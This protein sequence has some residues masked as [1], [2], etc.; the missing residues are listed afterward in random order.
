MRLFFIPVLLAGSCIFSCSSTLEDDPAAGFLPPVEGGLHSEDAPEAIGYL[1]AEFDRRLSTWSSLKNEKRNEGD[2]LK[3]RLLHEEIQRKA[4]KEIGRLIQTLENDSARKNREVAAAALGFSDDEAALS[5]LL[6]ALD[7]PDNSVIQKALFGLGI[8][9]SPQTPLAQISFLMTSHPDPITRTNASFALLRLTQR[10]GRSEGLAVECR[11]ALYDTEAGVRVQA[12][13]ILGMLEDADSVGP[14][15]DLL[16]DK[17]NLV[18]KAAATGL[19]SI[20]MAAPDQKARVARLM[21]D[22]YE[23]SSSRR[24]PWIRENMARLA[25]GD[26]GP[27]LGNWIDWAYRLP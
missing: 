19:A 23:R 17:V 16:A 12:A 7:D 6:A 21:V 15:G 4:K 14:L 22:A 1:L 5:P 27:E 20:G 2:A 9:A 10:G 11:S 25:E 18:A 26:L 3:V 24:R 8:L 13:T